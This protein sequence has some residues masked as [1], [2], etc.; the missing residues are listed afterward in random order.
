MDKVKVKAVV[1]PGT[2]LQLESSIR[3]AFVARYAT[4]A[5]Y[6]QAETPVHSNLTLT[7]RYTVPLDEGPKKKDPSGTV[8]IK[9]DL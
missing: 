3:P 4:P 2:Q 5:R 8:S 9:W 7:L 1:K 6:Y